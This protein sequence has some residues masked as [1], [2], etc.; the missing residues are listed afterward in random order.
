MQ[1]YHGT[2][3]TFRNFDLSKARNYKDFG[4]GIYLSE[5][6]WHAESVA[7]KRNGMHD[8]DISIDDTVKNFKPYSCENL[9]KR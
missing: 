7:K 2:D 3:K 1:Y 6:F 8:T 5:E 4:I 9:A